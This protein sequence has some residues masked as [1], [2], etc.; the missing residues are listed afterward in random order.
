LDAQPAA[1]PSDMGDFEVIYADR[2]L[3]VLDKPD[4]LL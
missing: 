3:L 1:I 2:H 4:G